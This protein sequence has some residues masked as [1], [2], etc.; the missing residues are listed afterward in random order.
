MMLLAPCR[1]GF[2]EIIGACFVGHVCQ[3]WGTLK[4][5]PH[6]EAFPLVDP[7]YC[8]IWCFTMGKM[9]CRSNNIYLLS[10]SASIHW[11]EV[12]LRRTKALN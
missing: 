9:K 6:I 10:L 7:P 3:V 11:V 12:N 5:R 2:S 1:A 4:I 8:Y